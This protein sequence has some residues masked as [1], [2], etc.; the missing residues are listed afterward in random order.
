MESGDPFLLIDT[1]IRHD[2]PFVIIG[3]HAVTYHGY[4]RATEDTDVVFLRS[5]EAE[6]S[7]YRALVELNAHWIGKDIDPATGIERAYPVSREYVRDTHLM[8]LFTDYG[9]LDIFDY[10]PGYP[11]DAV[12]HLVKSA[13]ENEG[14]RFV[15]LAWLRKMKNASGR[16]KDLIDLDNLPTP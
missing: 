6:T 1:L 2:V 4:V 10:I 12:D 13:Q 11:D 3:G 5:D 9:F 8:M 16:P 7:L 14:R 15:S